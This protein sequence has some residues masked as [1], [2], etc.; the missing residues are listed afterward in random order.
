MLMRLDGHEATVAHDGP[1]ALE[2]IRTDSPDVA[3]LDIGMPGMN[4]YEVAQIVRRTMPNGCP[5]LVAVTG[6]G[7]QGDVERAVAAGFDYHFTKPVEPAKLMALL[8]D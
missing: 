2:A 1:S 5:T 7:A 4:G 6:W 8:S 3:V